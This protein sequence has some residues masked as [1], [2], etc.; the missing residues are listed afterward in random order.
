LDKEAAIVQDGPSVWVDDRDHVG[1]G[2]SIS[3][4]CHH[5]R[6]HLTIGLEGTGVM[7]PDGCVTGGDVGSSALI[8]DLGVGCD[9]GWLALITPKERSDREETQRDHRNM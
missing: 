2:R 1:T 8:H 4:G 7:V 6:T 9:G 3:T 5:L